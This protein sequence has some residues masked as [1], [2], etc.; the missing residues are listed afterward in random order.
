MADASRE[1]PAAPREESRRS[2]PFGRLRRLPMVLQTE[3]TE[4]GLACLAMIANFH[5]H[6]VDLPGM[7]RRFSASLKGT[8]LTQI[9]HI[10][11]Q[12]R[13]GTRPLRLEPEDLR[14]LRTPCLL[15]WDLNHFVV[16]KSVRGRKVVIH[17]PARGVRKLH[18]N[19][20]SDHFTGIALEVAPTIA[21]RPVTARQRISMKSLIGSV[22]G[23][24]PSLLQIFGL[25]LAL[26]VFTL[27]TP[28]YLQWV[29]DHVLV[30]A[31]RNLLM[32]LGTGFL[33]VMFFKAAIN[34]A[35]SWAVV[36]LG[37]N[38]TVQWQSNLV[39]HLLKLPL[40]WYE[41]RHV[42]DIVSRLESA[43][44]IQRTL[45]NKFIGSVLDG[46]M[47]IG[48]LAIMAL[49]STALT[50]LVATLFVLYGVLRW[51][52]FGPLWNAS[53][54]QIARAARQQSDLLES[55]RGVVPIKLANQQDER[56]ARY[57]NATVA[58]I[59]SEVRVQWLNIV[60]AGLNQLLFG[61]GRVVLIWVAA[62]Q[63]LHA[64]FSAGML[65][66]FLAYADQF[67][68]RAAGLIDKWV[69][70]RMLGLHGARLGDI[71][72]SEPERADDCTSDAPLQDTS[73]ELRNVS[74]HYADG[75][76]WIVRNLNLRVEPGESVAITGASG[77]G[78]TTLAKIVLG[79]LQPTEGEVLFGGIPIRSL[80]LPRYRSMVGV[81]MQDDQ[82]FAGSIADNIS[83]FDTQA[84]PEIIAAA[85]RLAAID[86]EIAAM[87][88]G[89]QSLVGD[90]GTALSGGQRQRIIL[91]RALYRL[92][93]LLVLDEATSHLDSKCERQV[94][95]AVGRLKFT[96]LV[97]AHR[98]ET[99]ASAD[100]AIVLI[101]GQCVPAPNRR[102]PVACET[103]TDDMEA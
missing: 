88:M 17:D 56:S 59:N 58:T 75:E 57:A 19:E 78:K 49:Y 39:R 30:S 24:V 34:A 74:F 31:D 3:A 40:D 55:I 80:G 27:V 60:F 93:T 32:L 25:A 98:P 22:H 82:L 81:V 2:L 41:K 46:I 35:R 47:S 36:W 85:A 63:T 9:I 72:L 29:I 7:R 96:R 94:S 10:A 87:P 45:T 90:M 73:L 71:A 102:M 38:V 48:A 62:L 64:Q 95:G 21:F 12:L 11:G 15:H 101:D 54:D 53:E 6:N 28:F 69:D 16:L 100:R 18:L 50:S 14:C 66:A 23:L 97:I 68:T 70:F 61:G 79:L 67:S 42:G 20:V 103:H 92:P 83:F 86:N 26:E 84:K 76:P 51:A 33:G 37:A 91:A 4:C 43:H 65:V 13:F 8:S 99:V 77:C 5:G 89:Y 44:T 1:Q 52:F